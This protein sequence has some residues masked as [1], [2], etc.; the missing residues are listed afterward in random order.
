M[1][2]VFYCD[3]IAPRTYSLTTRCTD[4]DDSFIIQPCFSF[5]YF[6]LHTSVRWCSWKTIKTMMLLLVASCIISSP[7]HLFSA[8]YHAEQKPPESEKLV[9]SW[10]FIQISVDNDS[11]FNFWI[12]C[13][14]K[15]H[16]ELNDQDNVSLNRYADRISLINQIV[17]QYYRGWIW[18]SD[19]NARGGNS[20]S[21]RAS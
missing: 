1:Q 8:Q 20:C 17:V 19:S 14:L 2:D 12:I 6:L 5:K 4:V 11:R 21:N 3:N 7:F 13:L 10:K 18:A 16:S 15:F 9:C